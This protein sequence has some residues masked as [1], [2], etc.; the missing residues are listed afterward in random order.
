MCGRFGLTRP[1]ALKLERFGISELPPLVPRYNIPPSSDILVV[2]ERK[3]VTEAE[4][5]RW[6]LVPSWAKDPAIG[7]RMANVRSDTALEKSSFRAAMQKRRCLIP[8]DV[9]FE[10]QDVP[11]QK[12]RRPYAVALTDG[13]IFALGGLWEAWRSKEGGEWVITCAILTTEPNE[14]LAPIHDRMPVIIRPEDYNA[15]TDPST[16]VGDVGS[17]VAPFATGQMRAWEISLLVNDPKTDDVKILAPV[18]DS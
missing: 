5:I 3:G 17:M 8:A 7:H 10:W 14:L 9:F 15:W 18:P 2:R 12:R 13:E 11:G 1:E 16:Q 6:G 4:M